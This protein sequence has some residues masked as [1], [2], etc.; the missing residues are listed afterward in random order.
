M[1]APYAYTVT[2]DDYS[3]ESKKLYPTLDKAI[4][5]FRDEMEYKPS[6]F[7]SPFIEAHYA[8]GGVEY[9]D[10]SAYVEKLD[11]DVAEVAAYIDDRR[12]KDEE[13]YKEWRAKQTHTS[14][15][16]PWL[17]MLD[18]DDLIKREVE[19]RQWRWKAV[20]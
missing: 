3:A 16:S 14:T 4:E 5:A 9:P 19:A 17:F 11:V 18:R 7:T 12:R 20:S 15:G 6:G 10:L 1:S 8:D 13:A 2:M